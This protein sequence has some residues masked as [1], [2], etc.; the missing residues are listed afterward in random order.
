M[1]AWGPSQVL[2][3][4]GSVHDPSVVDICPLARH[5]RSLYAPDI[6]DRAL[7]A[8]AGARWCAWCDPRH[9][10]IPAR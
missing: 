8:R 6:D 3:D 1:A 2:H 5:S 10:A 9:S 4:D 7:L